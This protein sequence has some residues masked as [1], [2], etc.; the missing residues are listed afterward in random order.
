MI[1]GKP[2]GIWYFKIIGGENYSG[3]YTMDSMIIY[4]NRSVSIKSEKRKFFKNYLKK[5]PLG[6]I[7]IFENYNR[8]EIGQ[9]IK[10][11]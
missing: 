6:E 5:N 10:N 3:I 7:S 9:P 2:N 8:N 1:N 11:Y 4:N